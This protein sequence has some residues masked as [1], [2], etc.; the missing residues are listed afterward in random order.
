MWMT[1]RFPLRQFPPRLFSK[2]TEGLGGEGSPL[3]SGSQEVGSAIQRLS[4]SK[5]D[6]RTQLSLR[7]I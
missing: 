6:V 7:G 5:E 1:Q 2:E 3:G 4:S